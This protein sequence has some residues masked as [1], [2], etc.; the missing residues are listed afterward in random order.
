MIQKIIPFILLLFF[1]LNVSQS[2]AQR[3]GTAVGLRLGSN[4]FSRTIGITAQ[5]RILQNITIEGIAQSDFSRNTTLHVLLEKHRPIISKRFNYYYGLGY[6]LGWEESNIKNPAT[7]EI[8]TTYGN[9]TNGIDL[10]GGI[11][12]TILNTTVALDYKPNFNMSGR[13]EFYR[14]QIGVSV[15]TVIVKSKVQDKKRRQRARE[16]R[17]K[18]RTPLFEG[19]R[20]KFKKN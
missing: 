14:G 13:E 4:D 17:R 8:I 20:E 1:V 9:T 3:Y 11:E 12:M 10:I 15:R 5:Q 16:K 6:S 7:M 18:N 2:L 19:L